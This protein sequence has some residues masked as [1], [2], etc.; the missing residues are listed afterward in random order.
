MESVVLSCA[1]SPDGTML[2]AGFLGDGLGV[3][4]TTSWT[5]ILQIRSDEGVS[6][7]LF[8]P[9]SQQIAFDG[10]NQTV[11]VWDLTRGEE[12]LAMRGHTG[13]IFSV[14]Y[15][16]C[17][18]LIA[19]ASN[20]RTVRLWSSQT[21]ESL[22][23][24]KGHEHLAAS[25]MFSPD[26]RQ[27][28]SSS[29]DGTI[30]FWDPETGEPGCVLK[31]SLEPVH[32][33]AYS[34]DGK[35]IASGHDSG[36]LQLWDA[37][38]NEPSSVLKGHTSSVLGVAFSPNGR[39][40]ASASYDKTV[41]LW[42]AST[43][44]PI[45]ILSGHNALVEDVAFSPNGLQIAS[46]GHD[47]KVR[48]WDLNSS[49]SASGLQGHRV[50][51]LLKAAYSPDGLSILTASNRSVQQWD[52]KTGASLPMTIKLDGHSAIVQSIAYSPCGQWIAS[53]SEDK[54]VRL[55]RRRQEGESECWQCAGVVRAFIGTVLDVAWNPTT[56]MEFATRCDDN[57]VQVWQVSTND[58]GV[59]VRMLWGYNIGYLCA[60]DLISKD[61]IDLSPMNQKLL[62]Q[63][64]AV[65]SSLVP[66]G[67]G[68]DA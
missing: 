44:T 51:S 21:G 55:W 13:S 12:L 36:P 19:S 31:S 17:G 10:Y 18:K 30:R 23:V 65:D 40:I 57:S 58:E 60:E 49:W 43:G 24:L 15:S 4:S 26:G 54:T 41:R 8:S 42:D 61:A 64:G 6:S 7:V 67:E 9:N 38:S 46:G 35:W 34:P 28:V 47:K 37:V 39:W 3:Y 33:L 20:D 29:F 52:S 22:H 25:V 45:L 16:P 63:R 50:N 53:G 56:R 68:S 14:K 59:V 2:A 11:R 48:L 5:R 27:L 32:S 1:Y 62:V 66:E